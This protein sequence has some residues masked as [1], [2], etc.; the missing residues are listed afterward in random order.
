VVVGCVV[1]VFGRKCKIS[2]WF[3]GVLDD[4]EIEVR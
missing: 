2:C 1:C 3:L 4:E